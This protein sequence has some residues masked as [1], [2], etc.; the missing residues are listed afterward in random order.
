[1]NDHVVLAIGVLCAGLG[2][3]VFIRGAVGLAS[4]ARVPA[5]IIGATVAAFATSSPELAVGVSAG[6][7]GQPEVSFGDVLGSNVVNVGAILGIALLIAPTRLERSSL[8]RDFPVALLVPV[9]TALVALDG[10]VSRLDGAVLLGLFLAWLIAT[11]VEAR[12]QRTAAEEVLRVRPAVAIG[13]LALG[14]ALLVAA[15][16]LIVASATGLAEAMGIDPF[17]IG[18]TVVALGTSVPE[19]ATT[20][21]ARL[22]GHHEIAV[23]TILGSNIFNG[24]LIV[25]TVA[26]ICPVSVQL[27]KAMAGLVAGL[28]LVAL[29][30]PGRGGV[31][32]R[33][34]G[35]LLLSL[36]AIYVAVAI[37]LGPSA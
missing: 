20:V 6:L 33:R 13:S 37:Q 10:H 17:V 30:Y 32:G 16:R 26:A 34:R 21:I 23:G 31:L 5:G 7:R 35:A 2:G 19:L 29:T 27:Q 8:R 22:R 28:V 11:I 18:T 25:G 36:Y 3:E 1:M 15:G 14:L 12:R 24:L 4:W 9:G